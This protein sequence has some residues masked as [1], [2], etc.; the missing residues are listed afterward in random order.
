MQKCLQEASPRGTIAML[1]QTPRDLELKIFKHNG[2]FDSLSIFAKIFRM[3]LACIE[4]DPWRAPE[5]RLSK[6]T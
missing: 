3:K 5:M 1:K 4:Q 2:Y 6:A